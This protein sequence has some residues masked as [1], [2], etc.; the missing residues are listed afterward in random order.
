MLTYF[1]T[2]LTAELIFSQHTLFAKRKSANTHPVQSEVSAGLVITDINNTD[3]VSE[4]DNSEKSSSQ[5][6]T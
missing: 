2:N 4:R 3:S 6:T 5:V 1:L